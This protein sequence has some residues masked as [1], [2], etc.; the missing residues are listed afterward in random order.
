MPSFNQVYADNLDVMEL[1]HKFLRSVE[2]EK[3]NSPQKQVPPLPSVKTS[4]LPP[5]NLSTMPEFLR[6]Q[7]GDQT[8]N[9]M[10]N[11]SPI[12]FNHSASS[13]SSLSSSSSELLDF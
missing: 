9:E 10:P 5:K 4:T 6:D 7:Q 12:S 11:A 3:K 2:K 8:F 1:A 13:F